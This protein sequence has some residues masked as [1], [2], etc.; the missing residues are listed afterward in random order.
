MKILV[1]ALILVIGGSVNAQTTQPVPATVSSA[2]KNLYVPRGFDT[3]DNVQI[4]AEGSF[5][6]SCFKVAPAIVKV[7][8]ANKIIS[9]EAQAYRYGGLC[10]QTMIPFQ[11]VIDIGIIKTS[12]TYKVQTPQGVTL[13]TMDV[14]GSTSEQA[15]DFFYAPVQ[16]LSFDDK[17]LNLVELRIEFNHSCMKV[18]EV[19]IDKQENVIV[20]QPIVKLDHKFGCAVG[21][22]PT[23]VTVDLGEMKRGRYL[24]HVRSSG[25][26][27]YNQVV[28]ID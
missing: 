20:V 2:F 5:S 4:T 16:R 12:G 23:T 11:Q 1:L 27:A 22:F 24:L 17:K 26:Q 8:E 13:T 9:L 6:S 3:N 10:M 28:A 15:D 7:D 25:S 19:K 21:Y 14:K 18:A